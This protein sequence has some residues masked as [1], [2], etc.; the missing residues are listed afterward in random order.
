M[1]YVCV[2]LFLGMITAFICNKLNLYDR[3]NVYYDDNVLL[4]VMFSMTIWPLV[5][6]ALVYHM[7]NEFLLKYIN[8]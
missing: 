1:I 5:V 4:I 7:L 3:Q 2:Y 8:R 6:L